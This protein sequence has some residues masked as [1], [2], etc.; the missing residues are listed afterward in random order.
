MKAGPES[1]V[2]WRRQEERKGRPVWESHLCPPPL[3]AGLEP[4]AGV[5]EGG[6]PGEKLE[7]TENM[8]K[9]SK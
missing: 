1:R 5:P 4:E 2:R 3:L 7:L 9:V 8:R 6:P